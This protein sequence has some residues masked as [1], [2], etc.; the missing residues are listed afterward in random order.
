MSKASAHSR[1]PAEPPTA[2]ATC[3]GSAEGSRWQP[4]R[5][6]QRLLRMILR[7]VQPPSCVRGAGAEAKY[8][9][10]RFL[11]LGSR[12]LRADG[13]LR[14]MVFWSARR[15]PV[16]ALPTAPSCTSSLWDWI[17]DKSR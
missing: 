4:N 6:E 14:Q 8:R 17:I 2:I 1:I 5:H 12:R 15:A 3:G 11:F 13:S 16:A 9:R 7:T 10:A